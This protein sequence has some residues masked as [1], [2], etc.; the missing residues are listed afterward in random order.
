MG[1]Y[2]HAICFLFFMMLVPEGSAQQ[3][4]PIKVNASNASQY[5]DSLRLKIFG[6][7]SLPYHWLPD[8]VIKDVRSIDQFNY[9]GFPYTSIMYPSG[10][11]DSVDK[12]VV[13]LDDNTYYFPD[14]VKVY[15]FHPHNSN[16]KLFI[17]HA[18]HCA[19]VAPAEDVIINNRNIFPG[20]VIPALIEQGYTVLAVP[21]LNYKTTTQLGVYCG[22]D[23]HNDLFTDNVY[24]FPLQ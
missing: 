2:I 9:N 24:S 23:G 15:L 21:M 17:Y 20:L 19:G 12:L 3:V 18:G 6:S 11:L 7:A 10:N 4:T 14:K 22:Y 1:K 5:R 16:G 13:T 8:S